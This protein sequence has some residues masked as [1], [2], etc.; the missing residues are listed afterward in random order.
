MRI[1]Q[2]RKQKKH[3]L[4]DVFI[5]DK[6]EFTISSKAR[7][8][9][10][11]KVGQEISQEELEELK[12]T[13]E[14][15][16]C[17]EA[18]LNFLKYRMRSEKEVVSRLKEKNF[19]EEIINELIGKYKRLGYINNQAFAE[20]YLLDLISRRPQGR[21][22]LVYK[23]QEKGIDKDTIEQL[24]AKYLTKETELELAIRLLTHNKWKFDNLSPDERKKKAY[25][26][27]AQK[28]FSYPVTKEALEHV[29]SSDV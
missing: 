10:A 1:S 21:R 9:F 15:F 20:S 4:Y 11:P 17:E 23:L 6:L 25:A 7:K 14:R 29:Y 2:I 8:K 27:M 28:G 22:L 12:S 16:E 18:L 26:F 24:S 13:I 3:N 5:D 19:N